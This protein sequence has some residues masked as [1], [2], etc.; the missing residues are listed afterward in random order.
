MQLLLEKLATARIAERQRGQ[1]IGQAEAAHI[2]AIVRFDAHNRHQHFRRH[3][4]FTRHL[5]EH[6]AVLLVETTAAVDFAR[7][8]IAA[9]ELIPR[10]R[11]AGAVHDVDNIALIHRLRE[12]LLQLAFAHHAQPGLLP[13]KTL[14]LGILA[15]PGFRHRQG[16]CFRHRLLRLR[17]RR[18]RLLAAACSQHKQNG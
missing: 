7:A 2:A 9:A 5:V 3:A 4:V 10:T 15:E 1:R 6:L 11:R 14:H 13:D 18:N 17:H 12:K 8:G 16:R